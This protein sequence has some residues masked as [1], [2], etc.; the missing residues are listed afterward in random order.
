MSRLWSVG[1][2]GTTSGAKI[3]EMASSR[4][5]MQAPTA[6]LSWSSAPP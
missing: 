5:K 3:A 6:S 1:S 2:K 4:R